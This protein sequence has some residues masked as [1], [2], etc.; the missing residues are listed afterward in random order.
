MPDSRLRLVA[1]VLAVLFA[2][3]VYFDGLGSEYAPKNGDEFPYEHI[4]RLTAASGHLLPL[5]SQLDHMRNTKPPL[6]FWQGI[7]ST[8]WG[9]HWTQWHLRYPSVIYTLLTSLLV[10]LLAARFSG[11][12]GIEH[13]ETGVIAV[14]TYLAFFSTYRYGRPFL[15]NPPEVFWLFLPFFILLYWQ[16]RS[17]DSKFTVPLILGLVTGMGLLYKSFALLA[18]VGLAL[19]WWY[20]QHRDYHWREFFRQ[21]TG[22]LAIFGLIALGLFSLWFV[23]DPNP[24]A[25][26]QEFVVGENIGKF[27]SHNAGYFATMLWGGG[28]SIWALMLGYAVNAGLLAFPVLALYYIGFRNRRQMEIEQKLLWIWI[29]VLFLV[30]AIP[31]QR[32]ERYLLEGMPALAVLFALNWHRI[33]RVAFMLSLFFTAMLLALSAFL[34][35]HLQLEMPD[36]YPVWF[37]L[38]LLFTAAIMLFALLRPVYT[39]VLTPISILM[40]YLCYV[41]FLH[42][43]DGA[44]GNF[45]PEI[46]AYAKGKPIWVPCNFRAVDEQHRFLL[47]GADV[48]GY[49][50]SPNLTLNELSRRYRFFT[51]E[52]PMQEHVHCTGCKVIGHRLRLRNRQSDAEIK[53]ML[54]GNVFPN[55]FE[56][57]VL[58]ASS[59]V[60]EGFKPEESCR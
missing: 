31:N 29:I 17:F 14:L 19:T 48:H 32:S 4:T 50:E 16:P 60:P 20:L 58:V 56:K 24:K 45:S 52:L 13:I 38:L 36:L 49:Y 55:L 6:L 53:D 8:D 41:G 42:P 35:Y 30:F 22:K 11:R 33:S 51:V 18:P 15:V 9:K 40:F 5:V 57:E 1:S 12:K 47:P 37:Y 26:W 27:D 59:A 25:V 43:F 21:D 23:F 7:A 44:P 10:Y 2:I 34:V 46:Q 28:F 54:R 39:R 3:F